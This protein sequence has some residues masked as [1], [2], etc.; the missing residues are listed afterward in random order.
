MNHLHAKTRAVQ[1]NKQSWDK[2]IR[3][4]VAC[5]NLVSV[6]TYLRHNNLPWQTL[7]D[8]DSSHSVKNTHTYLS[9]C[10][11]REAVRLHGLRLSVCL[12]P[13]SLLSLSPLCLPVRPSVYL[14]FPPPLSLCLPVS[15]YLSS[16]LSLSTCLSFP[17][18]FCLPVSFL[19]S[20]SLPLFVRPYVS[21]SFPSQSYPQLVNHHHLKTYLCMPTSLTCE[22]SRTRLHNSTSRL[23]T[24][25][26]QQH[27]QHSHHDQHNSQRHTHSDP[28]ALR[29]RAAR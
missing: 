12:P 4:R 11:M 25:S 19:L 20:P 24:T 28:Q 29:Q 14:F 7:H 17:L 6:R 8:Q 16:S 13:I 22:I 21:G 5:E 2:T 26:P 10:D 23:K 27:Q 3:S 9:S 15:L 18:P 1:H